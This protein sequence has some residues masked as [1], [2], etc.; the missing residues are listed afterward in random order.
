MNKI[1]LGIF[2]FLILSSCASENKEV[3]TSHDQS[4]SM[5]SELK[6]LLISYTDSVSNSTDSLQLWTLVDTYEKSLNKIIYRYPANIDMQMSVSRQ[7]SLIKLTNKF[8]ETRNK[9]YKEIMKVD[10]DTI[11]P[12]DVES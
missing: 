4:V 6:Q 8:I 5:Y 12:A 2:I 9:R 11:S 1:K 7:D 3:D 10:V